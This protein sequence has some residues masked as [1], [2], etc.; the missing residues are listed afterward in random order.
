MDEELAKSLALGMVIAHLEY[1]LSELGEN[2]KGCVATL[3][4]RESVNGNIICV[5]DNSKDTDQTIAALERCLHKLRT[6]PQSRKPTH[7]GTERK[8]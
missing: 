2:L 3:I 7:E 8:Q 4:I 6:E 5:G 1:C